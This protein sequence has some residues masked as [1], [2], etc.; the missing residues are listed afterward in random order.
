[1]D[2]SIIT[3]T[4]ATGYIASWIVHDLLKTGHEVR[5]TVRNKSQ[6][7]KYQHLLDIEKESEGK[8][9]VYEADLLKEGS[10]DEAVSGADYV[11]HTASP[12]LLD[13]KNDPQKNLVD[14]A[15]NGTKNVLGAVNRSGSVKRVVL[16]SSLA[17]IYGDNKDMVDQ[18]LS[19]L[20]ETI[21]NTTSTINNG[22]YSYSKTEAEKA[23]WAMMKEQK[24]WSLVTIHPGFVLGPSLTKRID[25]TS[26]NTVLRILHGEI[27]IGSPDL[28]FIFSD[29]RDIS[30]GH[31]LAA[32]TEKA[33]GRYI[34]AN[35]SGNLLTLGK[36]IGAAYGDTYKVPKRL[37]PKWLVW[38]IA[39]TIGFTR[40][41]VKN[42]IGYP[43]SCDNSKSKKEL[44]M[45]YHMLKETIID[46][47]EQLKNDELI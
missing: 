17:A 36:I 7:E 6:V 34:I 15:V 23:A 38:L 18:G 41:Y 44:G 8:L 31:I 39:P 14:P 30:K 20:D 29:V 32:F 40:L 9:V 1:M 46:H 25:S 21:W 43:I 5:I 19:T 28:A 37:V 12:F 4:G 13:D 27:S 42:N 16:T 35:E 26:I 33:N 45:T 2:K 10:F 3:I 47:V 24:D 22:A 11:M